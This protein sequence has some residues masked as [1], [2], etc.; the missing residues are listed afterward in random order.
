MGKILALLLVLLAVG[1]LG[2]NFVGLPPLLVAENVVLAVVYGAFGWLVMRRPSRGV[3][4]ALLLVAAFNA[5]RVSRTL[6]SPVEGFG[7]L[8]AEHVPLF[9]Y[10]LV[11][12]ALALLAI[13]KRG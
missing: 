10:L 4:A 8:A 11:V 7:G 6:W 13:V 2:I 12:A 1:Y 5:G 9:I 3:Y